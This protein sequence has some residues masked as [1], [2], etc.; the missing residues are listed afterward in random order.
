MKIIASGIALAA[1]LIMGP[2]LAESADEF[3]SKPIRIVVPF[4]PGGGSDDS[5]RFNAEELHKVLN[6]PVVVENRPGASGLIAVGA[7]KNSPAD[8]Y[9]V[10]MATN[11]LIAVNPV[12][13]KN[14]PY[15]PFKD[16]RPVH[17]GAG[18]G[19]LITANVDSGFNTLQDAI[20]AAK[21]DKRQ[22]MVGTYSEGYELLVRWLGKE[23]N[24]EVVNVPYKGPANAITDLIGGRLDLMISDAA[25]PFELIRSDK[26]R[27][28]AITSDQRDAKLPEV[29]T[30]KESGYPEF[31]SYVWS[32]YYVLA[33]TPDDITRKLADAFRVALNSEASD[34]RRDRLPGFIINYALDEMGDFQ[35]K[36]YERFKMVVTQTGYRKD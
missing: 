28:L 3:P 9:T 11:S 34:A 14:L 15:D 10:L 6:V 13:M 35:R 16:L 20:D 7:V 17:G 18:T 4:S 29:P 33:D 32:S 12:T 5:S 26:L 21:K 8:G 22:L 36:E 31:E 30:M 23:A 27:G 1:S 19:A 2:A 24:A 25:S